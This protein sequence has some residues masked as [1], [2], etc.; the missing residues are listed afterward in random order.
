MLNQIE[1]CM[2]YCDRFKRTLIVETD[3][4]SHFFNKPLADY[5]IATQPNQILD[6]GPHRDALEAMEV[7][8]A[9]LAGKL[10]SYKIGHDVTTNRLQEIQSRVTLTF[11]FAQDY[12]EQL[13]VH[14]QFGGG[15]LSHLCL[16]RLRLQQSVADQLLERL[17]SIATPYWAI[18]IRHTDLTTDYQ[19]ALAELR[20]LDVHKLFVATDNQAVVDD[21]RAKLGPER[22][23]SFA[24]LPSK[25]GTPVHYEASGLETDAKNRAT[26]LDLLMLACARVLF[27]CKA[28]SKH[29]D[30]YSG[31]SLLARN[32]FNNRAIV[33]SL[34]DGKLDRYLEAH[35]QT[36]LFMF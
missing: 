35:E 10:H 1:R 24:T 21:F 15:E 31:Y 7:F 3:R 23:I 22:I 8:P 28:S 13:L 20:N 9:A 5:F 12:A 16:A 33:K 2:I 32:L 36:Y 14:H 19:A 27:L 25:A 29:Y 17:A 11:D 34:L 4:Y 30:G 18:H 26:I 6:A